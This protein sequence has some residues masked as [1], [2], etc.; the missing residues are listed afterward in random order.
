MKRIWE[1]PLLSS[2]SARVSDTIGI[3]DHE[4]VFITRYCQVPFALLRDVIAIPFAPPALTN[5]D[6]NVDIIVA[7]DVPELLIES[8]VIELMVVTAVEIVGATCVGT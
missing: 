2:R 4:S 3:D 6:P 8:S 5:S 1:V 7:I